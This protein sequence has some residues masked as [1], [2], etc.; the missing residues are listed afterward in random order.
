MLTYKVKATDDSG[1]ANNK[2]DV[3]T[4]VIT[5]NGAE[6]TGAPSP[7]K[8]TVAEDKHITIEGHSGTLSGENQNLL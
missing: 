4:I 7:D 5:I 8:A 3:Q 6:Q 2:S 1:V